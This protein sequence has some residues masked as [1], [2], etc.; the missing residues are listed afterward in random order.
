MGTFVTKVFGDHKSRKKRGKK[1]KNYTF[2]AN[3]H[4]A[5]RFLVSRLREYWTTGYYID[6][7]FSFR[8]I[9]RPRHVVFFHFIILFIERVKSHDEIFI[10]SRF[11]IVLTS[12]NDYVQ[13]IFSM[14]IM[15]ANML[16][17]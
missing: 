14:C 4:N 1:K 16:I 17:L 9:N 2:N 11:L 3:V 5:F 12:L 8:T 7:C 13:N 6:H 15:F 10:L